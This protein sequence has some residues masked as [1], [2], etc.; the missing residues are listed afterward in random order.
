MLVTPNDI[1]KHRPVADNLDDARRL[2]TYIAEVENLTVIPALG[3][4]LYSDV[5]QNPQSHQLLLSGG[6]YADGK[7]HFAGL[8]AAV[9]LLAYARFVLNNNINVTPFGVRE[10]VALDSDPVTDKSLIR[11]ANEAEN[12]GLAYLNQCLDYLRWLNGGSLCDGSVSRIKS[13]TFK[14]IGS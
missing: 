3:A 2:E 10:K 6:F 1:R 7:R 4:E 11:H 14:V 13:P 12:T 5:D 9:S 8:K